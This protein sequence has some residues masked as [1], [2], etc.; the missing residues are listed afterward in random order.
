MWQTFCQLLACV[1]LIHRITDHH[2]I[3]YCLSV[4]L[5]HI[6]QLIEANNLPLGS[7]NTYVIYSS[8]NYSDL[9]LQQFSCVG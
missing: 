6:M 1:H 7:W 3:S 9:L 4:N 5:K 2:Q 8:R